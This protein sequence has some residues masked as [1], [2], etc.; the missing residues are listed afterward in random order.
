MSD[1]HMEISVAIVSGSVAKTPKAISYS[2]VFDEAFKLAK[3]RIN[4][5]VIRSKAERDSFVHGIY[6]HGMKKSID[7]QAFRTM[8]ANVSRYP[9]SYLL[10][11]PKSVYWEYWENRLSSNLTDV[12]RNNRIDL[13]HAHFAYPEGQVGLLSK[14]KNWQTLDCHGS[15]FRHSCRA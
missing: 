11:N 3:N 8:L 14:K 1:L 12:I 13:I 4:V 10:R 6:F 7:A 15:W 2:F 9:P 5:H